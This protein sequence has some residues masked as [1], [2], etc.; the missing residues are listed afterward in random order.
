MV[1]GRRSVTLF[2][3]DRGQAHTLE[4]IIATIVLLSSLV[5]ALQVTAVTPLSASTASQ[6]I[7]NQQQ[8]TARGF[9]AATEESGAL[10]EALLYYDSVGDEGFHGTGRRTAYVND[11]DFPAGFRFGTALAETFTQRGV[12]INVFLYHETGPGE[13]SSPRPLVYRGAPSDNAVTASRLV[14]IYDDDVLLNADGTR[15]GTTVE[16][17]AANGRYFTTYNAPGDV[18]NV[19]RVEVVVWRM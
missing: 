2:E 1:A 3:R 7:E 15:S 6:H 18:Y 4:G 14:T 8:E 19:V 9:L 12:A 13:L 5:Y 10:R 11:A 16:T 17:A